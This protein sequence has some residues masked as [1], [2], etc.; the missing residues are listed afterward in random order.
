L[1]NLDLT[2]KRKPNLV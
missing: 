2:Q 1:E